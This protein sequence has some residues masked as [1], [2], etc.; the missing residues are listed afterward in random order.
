M[1]SWRDLPKGP[2]SLRPGCLQWQKP[3]QGAGCLLWVFPISSSVFSNKHTL[4]QKEREYITQ[5]EK[6]QISLLFFES[7]DGTGK[8]SQSEYPNPLLLLCF[9]LLF[10]W[11]EIWEQC[12]AEEGGYVTEVT[13]T[14][15]WASAH[16]EAPVQS[17]I[18]HAFACL[19]ACSCQQAAS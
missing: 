18:H 8:H 4:F 13:S 7:C 11:T 10:S 9:C 5:W 19:L 1:Y 6:S 2:P 15:H 17:E 12:Q 14:F 16:R 3:E